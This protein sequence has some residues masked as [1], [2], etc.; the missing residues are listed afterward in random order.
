M[1]RL[2]GATLAVILVGALI[3]GVMLVGAQGG[4]DVPSMINYQGFLTGNEGSLVTQDGVSMVFSLYEDDERYEGEVPIWQETQSV[5]VN[6]GLFDV[7][8]GAS[9]PLESGDLEGTRFLGISVNGDPEMT[10]R[11][12]LL[13]VAYAFWAERANI[14]ESAYALDALDDDP[15]SA[16]YVDNDGNIGIG[17]TNP[18]GKLHVETISDYGSIG[19]KDAGSGQNDMSL[20]EGSPYTCDIDRVYVVEA[21]D[22]SGSPDKF[23]WSDDDCSS[24]SS[25]TLEMSPSWFDLS[26]GVRI[27]WENPDGH[28]DGGDNNGDTWMFVAY[29]GHLDSLVVK[30]GNIGIGTDTLLADLD[31]HGNMMV[32]PNNPIHA[33]AIHDDGTTALDG[34]QCVYVSGKYAYVTGP[35]ED[36]VEILDISDPANPTHVGAITDNETTV[37]SSPKSIYV[38]GKYAYVA[39]IN[40]VEILDVSN[41]ANPTHAGCILDDEYGGTVSLWNSTGIY[42]SGRYA[43]VAASNDSG[44]QILDISDPANPTHVGAITD[45]GTTALSWAYGIYISGR[46][47]YVAS[48]GDSGVEILD[49]SDPANPTHVG[50]ITESENPSTYELDSAHSIYVSG[51]YAYVASYADDGVEILDISD[52]ANP[53]HVGAIT[54]SG[55]TALDGAQCIFVSGK[56]A[57][58]ASAGVDDGVEIL[59]IGGLDVPAASIGDIA[60]STVEVSENVDIANDLYVGNGLNV[61]PGG[62]NSAGPVNITDVLSLTPRSSEPSGNLGDLYVDDSGSLYLHNGI[63]WEQFLTVPGFQMVP[64]PGGTFSMGCT[65]VNDG[66]TPCQ[67]NALPVHTVTVSPFTMA[68]YEVNCKNWMEV[69]TW[70]ESNGYTFTGLWQCGGGYGDETHPITLIS[71]Y[72]AVLWCNALSEKDGLTPCYYTSAAKTTAHRSGQVDIET[73]WVD[74]NA[75]GYRLPTE[76]EWECACRADT[77]TKYHFGD[78]ITGSNANYFGSGDPLYDGTTPVGYYQVNPWGLCDMHGNVTEWCWDRWD[79]DYYSSSPSTDPR[80][81][82]GGTTYRVVRGGSYDANEYYGEVRSAY[83]TWDCPACFHGDSGF[84]PVR[85]N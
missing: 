14:A 59:D 64:I 70:A 48:A 78:A 52:P 11:Q 38:S 80:G 63:S 44:V 32:T 68:K 12:Q 67:D 55:P 2:I 27:R 82:S 73:D 60:A 42:V 29:H 76:A 50:A 51:K 23:R 21:T 16:V 66:K 84:R 4:A 37:L 40:G 36:G 85:S 31:L 20:D 72:D 65:E 35:L 34:A 71:W 13:S 83:R 18:E 62:I 15:V 25:A 10:P 56:Y 26:H 45:D 8:L 75:D 1:K 5:D 24:W 81:P 49:I 41:P 30:G 22:S 79:E 19:F 54:D 74:W 17:T 7:M 9:N 39:G 6:S 43:Y 53:V 69:K 58:V 33:G 3:G 61:G 28:H 46:Y 77:T 47:A 57:Y